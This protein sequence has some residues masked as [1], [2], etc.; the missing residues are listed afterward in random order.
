MVPY[1]SFAEAPEDEMDL[2]RTLTYSRSVAR[3]S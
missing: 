3:E 1:S 2:A